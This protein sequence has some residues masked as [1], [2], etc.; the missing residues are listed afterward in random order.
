VS[1]GVWAVVLTDYG[2]HIDKVFRTELEA[3]RVVNNQ[4]YGKVR[5]VEFG[6]SLTD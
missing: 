1:D 3:L 6:K 2:D 4:G 5:Y